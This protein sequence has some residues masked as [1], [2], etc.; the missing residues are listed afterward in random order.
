VISNFLRSYREFRRNI[1]FR[2]IPVWQ[3]EIVSK[4]RPY[5]MSGVERIVATISA[6][7]HIVTQSVPGVIVECGVWRGGQMMAAALT[8]QHL[9][10]LRELCLYDTFSGMTQPD[11]TDLDL[12]G[13]AAAP[14]YEASLQKPAGERWCEASLEDVS[15][16]IA[17]TGYPSSSVSYI[18]GPVEKT[19]PNKAPEQI[20]YLRLDTDWH[21]ST[22][23]ELVHLYPRVAVHGVVCID[24]YGHWQGARKATEEYLQTHKVP[25]LLH[26]IDY[27]GRQFV[28]P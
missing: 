27:S 21:A 3:R 16:N 8:L 14:I 1:Q 11:D 25:A 28:K 15:R 4:A 23:H 13:D 22:M 20:A 10:E 5:T 9:G 7:E 12:H 26:R 6:V 18:V 2:D 24:D 19:L 17:S